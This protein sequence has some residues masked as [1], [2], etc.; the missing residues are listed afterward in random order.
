M[1]RSTC[2]EG[3]GSLAG[4]ECDRLKLDRLV[5]FFSL[6]QKT[7]PFLPRSRII[8]CS[9]DVFFF[10]RSKAFAFTANDHKNLLLCKGKD[11]LEIGFYIVDAKQNKLYLPS[12]VFIIQNLVN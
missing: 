4:R 5:L 9:S 7:K 1:G 8:Y 2:V 11:K 10:T 12:N 6:H 3:A